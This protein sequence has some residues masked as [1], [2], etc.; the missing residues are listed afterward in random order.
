MDDLQIKISCTPL[1]HLCHVNEEVSFHITSNRDVPLEA[2]ISIDGETILEKRTVFAPAKLT[3]SLPFPGFLRCSVTSG[4]VKK[5]C[6]VG[7]DPEQ[8]TT[9][10]QEPDDFDAFWEKSFKELEEIPADFR[11]T[12]CDPIEG[13]DIFRIDCANVDGLRF[14]AMLALPRNKEK[15]APLMVMFSGGEAYISE[16]SFRS[17]PHGTREQMGVECAVLLFQLPPYPPMVKSED[18]KKRHEE[19]LKEIGLRRYVYYGLDSP[20]KFYAYPAILGSLRLLDI[21]AARDDINSNAIIYSGASHGGGF[22]LYYC[23]FSKHIKAAFCGVPNFG[24]IAGFLAGRHTTDS[25]AP[26]FRGHVETRK[27]FDS[28]FCARR[29]T[30]PVFI[31]VGFVD[32]ACAPTAVYAIYNNLA[33]PKMIYNKINHGHGDA[34][35]DY[36]PIYQRWLAERLKE[37]LE[38]PEI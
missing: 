23:C 30:V 5:E 15:K 12:P 25:N 34:P 4:D 28:A 31:G 38:E 37:L 19:F 9:L 21:V 29:I 11:M 14:Y 22:G 2:V 24:D 1:S 36:R 35:G 32:S 18:C 6:G 8:I 27:Y 33:G 16:E 26:E 10:M 7:V 20:K 17:I 13:F 3:A